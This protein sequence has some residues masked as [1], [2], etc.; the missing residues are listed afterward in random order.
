[1][2]VVICRVDC[3]VCSNLQEKSSKRSKLQ[4]F[5][6]TIVLENKKKLPVFAAPRRKSE[7][8]SRLAALHTMEAATFV[9]VGELFEYPPHIALD[10]PYSEPHSD[11]VEHELELRAW[12]VLAAVDALLLLFSVSAALLAA[13]WRPGRK[14]MSIAATQDAARHSFAPGGGLDASGPDGD[15]SGWKLVSSAGVGTKYGL[16]VYTRGRCAQGR[17]GGCECRIEAT[18]PHGVAEMACIFGEVDLLPTWHPLVPRSAFLA[19]D[20]EACAFTGVL[21]AALPWPLPRIGAVLDLQADIDRLANDGVFHVDATT[22]TEIEK[23]RLPP[24]ARKHTFEREALLTAP[25]LMV[26]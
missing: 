25:L 24:W 14:V 4:F 23:T 1:M 13:S 11:V 18:A 7:S 10:G 20:A 8:T 12:H 15:D 26:P 2:C 21:E 6:K 9:G 16:Q 5:H 22:D 17:C 19:L 3:V